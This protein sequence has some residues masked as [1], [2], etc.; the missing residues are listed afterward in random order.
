MFRLLIRLIAVGLA[1]AVVYGIGK[2]AGDA[3]PTARL[4]ELLMWGRNAMIVIVGV[5]GLMVGLFL[6][7]RDNKA[8]RAKFACEKTVREPPAA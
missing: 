5:A 8:K 1:L 6:Y 2:L 4:K 3:S 7:C